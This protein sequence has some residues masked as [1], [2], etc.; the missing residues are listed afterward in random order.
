MAGLS[1]TQAAYRFYNDRFTAGMRQRAQSLWTNG[2]RVMPQDDDE[3]A[4][5][6]TSF[7]VYKDVDPEVAETMPIDELAYIVDPLN[8]TCTC[9]FF[10][11]QKTEP[12]NETGEPVLCKHIAGLSALVAEEIA[13]WTMKADHTG[14]YR[15]EVQ[16]VRIIKALTEA[17]QRVGK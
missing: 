11:K 12:L 17:M 6:P 1:N 10:C 3:S 16:Y 4:A 13:Y 8:E 2:Y 15:R 9:A 7:L 14:D 5:P